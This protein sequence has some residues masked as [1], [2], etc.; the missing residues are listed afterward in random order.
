[1][2]PLR[3]PKLWSAL[4]WLLVVGVVVSS[5]LPGRVVQAVMISDKIMHAGA[6]ALLMM[7]FAGLYRRG[8]Y[9]VIGAGLFGLGLALDLM[10]GLTRTR[11]FDWHDVV[12]NLAGVLVGCA[13]A[14][15]VLGGWC[16]R[17]ERRLLS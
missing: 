9:V 12:A 4:G 3:F 6:Y 2:L 13:L 7:W 1:M 16:Q 17:I 15:A 11:M 5:L 14:F 8:L 10:Q